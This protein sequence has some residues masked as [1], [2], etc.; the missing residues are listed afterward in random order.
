MSERSPELSKLNKNGLLVGAAFAVAPLAAFIGIRG[1]EVVSANT[2]V[3]N[4]IDISQENKIPGDVDGDGQ[5]TAIDAF[6]IITFL[7]FPGHLMP[8]PENAD[9][10]NDGSIN[11]ID[12]LI[13]L[14]ENAGL[15]DSFGGQS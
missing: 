9:I 13:V 4:T 1:P 5:I 2:G 12:A 3:G 11:V 8:F 6:H 7:T 14:Q 15:R 10:D